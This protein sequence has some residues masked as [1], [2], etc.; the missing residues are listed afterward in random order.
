GGGGGQ[1]GEGARTKQDAAELDRTARLL[2]NSIV[3]LAEAGARLLLSG[4]DD[5]TPETLGRELGRLTASAQ[6]VA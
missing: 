5:W 4:A 6:A 2:G 3:G 1:G